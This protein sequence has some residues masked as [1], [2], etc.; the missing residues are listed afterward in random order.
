MKNNEIVEKKIISENTAVKAFINGF[1]AYG[2]IFA[3]IIF[4]A[5]AFFKLVTQHLTFENDLTVAISTSILS[6]I[7]LYFGT[8]FLCRLSTF[9]VLKKCKLNKETIQNINKKMSIF[10]VICAI[11]SLFICLLIVTNKYTNSTIDF[12]TASKNYYNAFK[13]DNIE[14]ANSF[15]NKFKNDL[16]DDWSKFIISTSILEGSIIF[17]CLYL[18]IYQ[19]KMISLYN[20]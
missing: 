17:S 12:Q 13:D 18:I 15:I 4:I 7:T 19:K 11:A 6:A 14:I 8:L 3:F 2:F 9:D 10:F 5:V 20:D 1:I 16:K